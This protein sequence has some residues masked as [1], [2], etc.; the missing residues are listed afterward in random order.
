MGPLDARVIEHGD[1][2]VGHLLER[3][4]AKGMTRVDAEQALLEAVTTGD[5]SD[6]AAGTEQEERV[7][8]RLEFFGDVFGDIFGGGRR[9]R[10]RVFRGADL[11]YELDLDLEQAAFGDTVTITIPVMALRISRSASRLAE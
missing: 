6:R 11:R 3:R 8:M 1:G 4:A 7:G 10:S 9:G 2:V 5:R